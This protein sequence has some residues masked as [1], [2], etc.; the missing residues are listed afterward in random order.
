MGNCA[1]ANPTWIL[2]ASSGSVLMDFTA[3]NLNG[4]CCLMPSIFASSS[5]SENEAA[6]IVVLMMV[7]IDAV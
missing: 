3:I 1:R 2:P 6:I 4:S 7:P 5:G